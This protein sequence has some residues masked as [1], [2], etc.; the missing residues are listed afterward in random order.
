MPIV[1]WVGVTILLF[2]TIWKSSKENTPLWK[3]S[4][5]VLIDCTDKDNQLGMMRQIKRQMR[6]THVQLQSTGK[7]PGNNWYLEQVH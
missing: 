3:S 2:T 1:L 7:G 4:P 5:L 6:G